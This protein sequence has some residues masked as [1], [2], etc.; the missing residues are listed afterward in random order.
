MEVAGSLESADS[1]R[2]IADEARRRKHNERGRSRRPCKSRLAVDVRYLSVFSRKALGLSYLLAVV[3]FSLPFHRHHHQ[4]SLHHLHTTELNLTRLESTRSAFK[5]RDSIPPGRV[6]NYPSAGSRCGEITFLVLVVSFGASLD[7][8]RTPGLASSLGAQQP[9][10]NE[11]LLRFASSPSH[12]CTLIPRD[13]FSLPERV[14][15]HSNLTVS[16]LL[17]H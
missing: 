15:N 3:S 2:A 4:A 1:E 13:I 17:L 10:K 5:S 14:N 6:C 11:S 16:K 9:L 8:T 12:F 7:L